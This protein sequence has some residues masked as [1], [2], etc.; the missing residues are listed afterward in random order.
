MTAGPWSCPP[1]RRGGACPSR[2]NGQLTPTGGGRAQGPPLGNQR[3]SRAPC[4]A[5]GIVGEGL[6]PS[7]DNGQLT[8]TGG[9]RAQGPPLRNRRRRRALASHSISPMLRRVTIAN[10]AP[11]GEGVSR[12]SDGIGF[13]AGALPGEEVDAEVLEVRRKFW[14]GRAAAILN[15]SALR[16]T[17]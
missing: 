16:R 5:P 15:R 17:G 13:V 3:R 11:T 2:D 9:G 6:A 1:Y 14:K 4:R 10:L 12:T 8:P 7:R